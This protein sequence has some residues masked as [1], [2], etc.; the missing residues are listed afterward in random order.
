MR[1]D[2]AECLILGYLDGQEVACALSEW[3]PRPKDDAVRV[4]IARGD[5]LRIKVTPLLP[6]DP[7][8]GSR[9]AI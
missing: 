2:S 5:P 8:Q 9:S 7:A 4:G 1:N 3:T 6:F